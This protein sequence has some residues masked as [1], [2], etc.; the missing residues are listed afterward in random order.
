M[1]FWSKVDKSGDCWVWLGG[2][3]KYGYGRFRF[4]SRKYEPAHRIAWGQVHPDETL[5]EMLD[6][7]CHNRLCVK[8][9]H[10]RVANKKQNGENRSPASTYSKSGFR[11][12]YWHAGGQR[13]TVTLNHNGRTVYGGLYTDVED[14]NVAA[15]ALRNKH[16]THNESDK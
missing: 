14:A 8:P 5:P 6:H 12:V 13:W 10:L 16:F 11:N 2:Q 1:R 3:N 4:S 7:I 15:I 9:S